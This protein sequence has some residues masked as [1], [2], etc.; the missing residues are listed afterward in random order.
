[1]SKS[2]LQNIPDANILVGMGTEELAGY[3]LE[4]LHA[5]GGNPLSQGDSFPHNLANAVSPR[6][7][8]HTEQIYRRIVAACNWLIN[9]GFLDIINE[10]G[11]YEISSKGNLVKTAETFAAQLNRSNYLTSPASR[12]NAKDLGMENTQYEF[13]RIELSDAE[14]MWLKVIVGRFLS[15]YLAD[16]NELKKSLH[17]QGKWP[18]NFRPS[19]ID[20][21]LFQRENIPTLLGVWHADP[22]NALITKFD[23]LIKYLQAQLP[24]TKR[25]KVADIALSIG[26][27]E[28]HTSILI[29]LLPSVGLGY[30]ATGKPAA[31]NRVV[32]P[33]ELG[34]YETLEL[35]DP[36]HMDGYLEYENLQAQVKRFYENDDLIQPQSAFEDQVTEGLGLYNEIQSVMERPKLLDRDQAHL[37][38]IKISAAKKL[39]GTSNHEQQ[40]ELEKWEKKALRVLPPSSF[41]EVFDRAAEVLLEWIWPQNSVLRLLVLLIALFITIIS[42]VV[43][44]KKLLLGEKGSAPITIPSNSPGE[45]STEQRIYT[46]PKS[47]ASQRET[48]PIPATDSFEFQTGWIT[49]DGNLKLSTMR[50]RY[51]REDLGDEVFLDMVEIPGG[52][53]QMGSKGENARTREQPQHEV[54]ITGFFMSRTEVTQKQWRAVMGRNPPN[55]RGDDFPVGKVSWGKAKEFCRLLEKKT[56]RAYRLPSEAEWEYSCRA[57]TTTRFAFG[58]IITPEI[59]NYDPHYPSRPSDGDLAIRVGSLGVG[60]RFGL[61]DMHGNVWEWCEDV[62]HETYFPAPRDGSP[63]ISGS[64][65]RFRVLRGGSWFTDDGACRCAH[66]YHDDRDRDDNPPSVDYGFRLALSKTH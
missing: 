10:Q 56:G 46:E 44:Y 30:A 49:P 8:L 66:R 54:N 65:P 27:S 31:R 34:I 36:E 3:V 51:F 60:N 57:G 64:D 4:H 62:Y 52:K 16:T 47:T 2:L 32:L 1:V 58:D 21:R 55:F 48:L 63:W 61:F 6:Y 59:V 41:K 35:E 18:K 15:G 7:S 13:P 42:G 17:T 50:A 28:A 24:T 53:F 40:R 33:G 19:E 39:I 5:K 22:E 20:Y 25:F 11:F 37:M 43:G 26:I 38:V 14:L 23:E 45:A 29:H 9:N 12:A